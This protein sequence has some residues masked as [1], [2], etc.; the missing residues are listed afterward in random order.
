MAKYA[1]GWSLSFNTASQLNIVQLHNALSC[2]REL[3]AESLVFNYLEE[4]KG[5]VK[6]KDFRLKLLTQ[7]T[8][9]CQ[10]HRREPFKIR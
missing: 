5:V 4:F 9:G 1:S 3:R 2:N 6:L 8:W 7:M 10:K